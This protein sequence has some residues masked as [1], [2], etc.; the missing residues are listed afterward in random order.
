MY[1]SKYTQK[2]LKELL[3]QGGKIIRNGHKPVLNSEKL[4]IINIFSLLMNEKYENIK[5]FEK[6]VEKT[7]KQSQINTQKIVQLLYDLIVLSPSNKS[8]NYNFQVENINESLKK[9]KKS[10]KIFEI[11]NHL[12]KKVNELEDILNQTQQ[13]ESITIDN[14]ITEIK[15]IKNELIN[16]DNAINFLDTIDINFSTNV[17]RASIEEKTELFKTIK[18]KLDNIFKIVNENTES[19]NKDELN[20]K[21]KKIDSKVKLIL[22]QVEDKSEDKELIS[23]IKE[24]HKICKQLRTLSYDNKKQL[25]SLVKKY[26]NKA[27]SLKAYKVFFDNNYRVIKNAINLLATIK[28][29]AKVV[30]NKDFENANISLDCLSEYENIIK[31][32]DVRAFDKKFFESSINKIKKTVKEQ[33]EKITKHSM[34]GNS[35]PTN[36]KILD[37]LDSVICDNISNHKNKKAVKSTLKNIKNELQDCTPNKIKDEFKNDTIWNENVE[38]AVCKVL[39]HRD[40][41]KLNYKS[42]INISLDN[43]EEAWKTLTKKVRITGKKIVDAEL[44]STP[45]CDLG[46]FT[47]LQKGQGVNSNQRN[48]EHAINLWKTE[49][50]SGEKILFSALRHGNTRGKEQST[51]EIILAAAYQQYGRELL[52]KNSSKE[53]PIKVKLGNIQLMSPTR[54][55]TSPLSPDEDLPFKQM[56]RFKKYINNPFETTINTKNG[57][58]S[59]WLKLEKPILVN[60]GTNIQHYA[61]HGALVTSSNKQN[62]EAFNTLF[63]ESLLEQYLENYSKNKKYQLRSSDFKENGQIGQWILDENNQNQVDYKV[64]LKKIINLS[65]QILF[66][67]CSTNKKGS[68]SN[69]AA[70]QTRLAALM[71]LIGYPVSFN[72]KSGKDRTGEVAAEINDLVLNME[73]NNGEVPDPN[74]KLS[75]KDQLESRKVLDA[76]QS[77]KIAQSNTGLRGLK[78]GYKN[79]KKNLGGSLKGASKHA[80]F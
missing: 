72:C 60:F 12:L 13:T 46:I 75:I 50:K 23:A 58:K 57:P 53:S 11:K 41:S 51:K 38:N 6:M 35:T 61:M 37:K 33:L 1:D 17:I 44:T 32:K 22:S 59:I 42:L 77:D 31:N 63:G 56:N 4:K 39:I 79:T 49:V 7:R 70:I 27:F 28:K 18:E 15:N 80:K 54:G 74:K 76:T 36:N 25:S 29:Y 24:C 66:L 78:V 45:A 26:D 52:E 55:L 9:I 69:P 3:R 8:V 2:L 64:K 10:S 71:Y 40:I 21:I 47:H 68:S 5:D 30:N 73:A 62:Q 65:N 67:W 34:F 20:E 14:N 16:P 19:I 48:A 43:N